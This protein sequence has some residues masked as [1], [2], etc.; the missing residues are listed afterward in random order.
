MKMTALCVLQIF[1]FFAG[2]SSCSNDDIDGL[3]FCN[4]TFASR[5]TR[6]NG[7]TGIC[8]FV[9]ISYPNKAEIKSSLSSKMTEYWNMTKQS[10]TKQSRREYGFI[11][12]YDDEN[13]LIYAGE[14]VEGPEVDS[15]TGA[16]IYIT[17][18]DDR[19]SICGVF[20]THTPATYTRVG[21]VRSTGPSRLDSDAVRMCPEFVYDYAAPFVISGHI[22]DMDAKI[23]DYGPDKR[24]D[25]TVNRQ[26]G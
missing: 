16:C 18:Y 3:D 17:N 15:A 14:K 2:F 22:K 6:S 5:M 7:E 12:Y 11:I 23:Y 4:K 26:I 9:T 24:P 13:E 20:H 10:A 8:G 25:T 1:V 21:Y 19:E